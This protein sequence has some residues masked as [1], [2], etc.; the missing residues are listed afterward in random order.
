MIIAEAIPTAE[1]TAVSFGIWALCSFLALNGV[2]TLVMLVKMFRND[3]EKREVTLSPEAL[4][5][6]EFDEARQ[7]RDAEV[8]GM[9]EALNRHID[10]NRGEHEGLHSKIGGVERGARAEL[11]EM[12]AAE[13]AG[14]KGIHQQMNEVLIALGELRGEIRKK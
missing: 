4:T 13:S 1:P 11:K 2:L 12:I 5:R 8:K 10:I 9:L 6:R 3:P 14:R 7:T